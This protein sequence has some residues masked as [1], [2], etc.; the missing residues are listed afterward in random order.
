MKEIIKKAIE[1]TLAENNIEF[2]GE[3]K[4]E[5]PTNKANGDYSSN[6]AMQLAKELKSSPL[7]IATMLVDKINDDKIAKVEVANPG[8]I[9]FFVDKEYLLDN[10]NH[11]IKEGANYGKSRAG[12]NK[13]VNVE[14]V[15][16][17]P[18]G[19]I[20]IGTS[21]NAA[22][23]DNI[24]RI[25]EFAGY[26]VTREYYFNDGGVQIENLGKSTK[27][28]YL[29]L[30]EKE[31]EF[32]ENGYHG[33]E[34]KDIAKEIMGKYKDTKL[35]ENIEYFSKYASGYLIEIIKQ[36]LSDFR[37]KFDVW[38]KEQ[39]IRNSGKIE[40][41]LEI[42]KN[43]NDIYE[44]EGATWLASSKYGDDKDR[45]VIK[46]DGNYTYLVPDIA[47]HLDKIN[48]GY[49]EIVDVL[50]ADHHGYINRLKAS[51]EAL[52]FDPNKIHIKMIQMVKLL[53]DGE[54]V[55]MSKR[56][57]Q[58]V[59][60]RELM[61]DVGINAARYFFASR[62][63][64]TQMDFD[65]D[66]AKKTSSEN[67]VFYVSYAYARICTILKEQELTEIKK[68]KTIKES[69]AYNVLMQV[70]NFQEIVEIAAEKKLPH[71]I[72]NYV[73][74]LANLFH[75]FY[76]KYRIIVPDKQKTQENLN[77]INAIKITINNAL[78]LIGV[79]P[80]ERM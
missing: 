56:T 74:E 34:I 58:T 71:L 69:D 33:M 41:S 57:G 47:Y 78:N 9:N 16:A 44:L 75:T 20:H 70:Y 77:M 48:R 49:D 42:L 26:K 15:S 36:D 60:M 5:I 66:L 50:G 68:Y 8:F 30:C 79:E 11:V 67:P 24:S 38:T 6:I 54:E 45:V 23:G 32:P 39:D 51:V 1:K 35:N 17:N 65:L 28:R 52:G 14:F 80:P 12:A 10:I 3:I 29:E 61:D 46:T 59:T 19:L 18:T 4:I 53:R 25:L 62:S 40:K 37:V 73:Y 63:N 27:A 21:R 55:K 76:S 13:K 22:Y 43:K 64:D 72:T 7:N 31:V 2:S